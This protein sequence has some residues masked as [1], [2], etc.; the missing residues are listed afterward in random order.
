[1]L[2]PALSLKLGQFREAD[3]F[4]CETTQSSS[5]FPDLDDDALS[6]ASGASP[7]EQPFSRTSNLAYSDNTRTSTYIL[8]DTYGTGTGS[9]HGNPAAMAVEHAHLCPSAPAPSYPK[10]LPSA[11]RA[12][13]EGRPL[14]AQV[15]LQHYEQQAY[16]GL[17]KCN[18]IVPVLVLVYCTWV[19]DR[20]PGLGAGFA[21]S[22][23]EERL[24]RRLL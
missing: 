3:L 6:S 22:P 11:G 13:L 7:I 4:G 19:A 15:K 9:F 8:L 17:S 10:R 23:R 20:H 2:N 18:L 14:W 12:R 24:S 21:Q 1:M 5:F 16:V